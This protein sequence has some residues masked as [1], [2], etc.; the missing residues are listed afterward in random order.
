MRWLWSEGSHK[1]LDYKDRIRSTNYSLITQH[2]VLQRGRSLFFFPFFYCLS[3]KMSNRIF[4]KSFA[5][6]IHHFVITPD[7]PCQSFLLFISGGICLAP[8]THQTD[9]FWTP[10]PQH[11]QFYEAACLKC[12]RDESFVSFLMTNICPPFCLYTIL[13]LACML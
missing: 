10:F 5:F 1:F 12:S 9:S 13:I 7:L 4:Q 11:L 8:S 2:K 6:M 3:S